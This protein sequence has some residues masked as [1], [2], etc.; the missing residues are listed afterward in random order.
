MFEHIYFSTWKRNISYDANDVLKD[1]NYSLFADKHPELLFPDSNYLMHG[2]MC[3]LISRPYC[4]N[5]RNALIYMQSFSYGKMG[6]NYYTDRANYSSYLL[7]FTYRGEGHLQYEGKEYTLK[8]GDLF[9][10][11]CKKHH[12]YHTVGSEW[13]HSDLHLQGLFIEQFY[14][15]YKIYQHPVFHFSNI[16]LYQNALEKALQ[17]QT[18]EQIHWTVRASHEFENLLF[19]LLEHSSHITNHIQPPENIILLRTYL[20]HN[21]QRDL[22]LDEM[23][24]FCNI[25]KYHLCREF[26]RHIGFSPKEYIIKLRINQAQL[27]LQNTNI[28][29]YKIGIMCGFENEANFIRQF[30]KYSGMTPGKY[31][32]PFHS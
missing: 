11:D 28:S 3:F 12:Y 19:L 15:E 24:S 4:E 10:I 30:K 17:I 6:E 20:E 23:S 21:F 18:S 5:E 26:K 1:K 25:S 14:E 29:G 9:F 7:L 13:E 16:Q 31:R 22:S 2:D 27:L 8:E 32:E